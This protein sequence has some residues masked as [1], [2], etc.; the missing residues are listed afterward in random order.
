MKS[1][2]AA[3]APYAEPE[4]I[5]LLSSCTNSL[6]ASKYLLQRAQ[7]PS[8][9]KSAIAATQVIN[10]IVGDLRNLFPSKFW[11]SS[12]IRR[13]DLLASALSSAIW[14]ICERNSEAAKVADSTIEMIRDLG[15]PYRDFTGIAAVYIV[16]QVYLTLGDVTKYQ[17]CLQLLL[18]MSVTH[19][20]SS[21]ALR[22][23]E[24]IR[25]EHD[26]M[27][28]QPESHVLTRELRIMTLIDL[29]ENADFPLPALD[30]DVPLSVDDLFE[31]PTSLMSEG[32]PVDALE[33]FHGPLSLSEPL[34]LNQNLDYSDILSNSLSPLSG[35]SHSESADLGFIS[36]DSAVPQL[37]EPLDSSLNPLWYLGDGI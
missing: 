1:V 5:R 11:R 4:M 21:L 36:V 24:K 30:C 28:A 14:L 15:T 31:P 2:I 10:S 25:L 19:G 23:L 33:A 35:D 9:A 18:A 17:S 37:T 16:A 26:L 3:A 8:A 7:T 32:S 13:I 27:V 22:S 12:V 34:S 29:Q 20:L 6:L